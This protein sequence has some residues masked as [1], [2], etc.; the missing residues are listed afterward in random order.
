MGN[1]IFKVVKKC[2]K[3]AAGSLAV[4]NNFGTSNRLASQ[5]LAASHTA[6]T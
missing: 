4:V 5:Q 3:D 6:G 2:C 1:L